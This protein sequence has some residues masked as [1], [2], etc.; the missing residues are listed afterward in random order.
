MPEEPIRPQITLSPAEARRF[1]LLHHHLLPPRQLHGKADL[2]ALFQR[3]GCIQFDPVNVIAPSP[4]V[5]LQA[6]VA[7][8][9]PALLNELLYND[10]ELI[11]D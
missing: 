2:T 7:D 3:L 9:T 8:Y 11:N 6:R 5:M 10:R 1:M 4:D